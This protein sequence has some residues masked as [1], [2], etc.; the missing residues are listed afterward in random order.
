MNTPEAT[1]AHQPNPEAPEAPPE[2][3]PQHAVDRLRREF[4]QWAQRLGFNQYN[5]ITYDAA[6]K[7]VA[8]KM[9]Q[10]A[11]DTDK[12]QKMVDEAAKAA[13]EN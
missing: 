4:N 7:D 1:E 6:A 3:T 11:V 10:I 13:K 9:A 5:A 2:E 12:Y 8:R